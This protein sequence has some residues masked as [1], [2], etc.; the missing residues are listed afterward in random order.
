WAIDS[1]KLS[2]AEYPAKSFWPVHR[3][4]EDKYYLDVPYARLIVRDLFIGAI[5]GAFETFDR[6]VVD[7]AVNGAGQ[8]TRG[9]AGGL[10]YIQSGQFQ[11]YGAVGFAGLAFAVLL[12]LV[13]GP[14]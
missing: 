4:L 8:V 9:A 3:L 7:G 13:L 10:R 2:S 1:T 11:V 5:G 6:V 12:A 14:L